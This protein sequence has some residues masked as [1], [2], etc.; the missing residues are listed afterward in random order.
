MQEERVR[1]SCGERV[2]RSLSLPSAGAAWSLGVSLI[3]THIARSEIRTLDHESAALTT[4]PCASVFL[5]MCDQRNWCWSL[6]ARI[7]LF[8]RIDKLRVNQT[9]HKKWTS[10]LFQ[11]GAFFGVKLTRRKL[12]GRQSF[13]SSV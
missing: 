11:T 13:T 3:N 6:L 10:P 7:V 2:S 1:E 9:C 5:D 12:M 4:R 8:C